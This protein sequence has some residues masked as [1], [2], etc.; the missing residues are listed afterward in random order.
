MTLYRDSHRAADVCPGMER[1]AELRDLYADD[2][3][4]GDLGGERR[5]PPDAER[6]S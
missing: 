1:P 4:G 2:P 3:Q 5:V 6:D